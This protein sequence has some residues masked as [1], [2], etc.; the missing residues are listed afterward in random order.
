MPPAGALHAVVHKEG[1]LLG[2]WDGEPIG[3]GGVIIGDDI[4]ITCTRSDPLQPGA[5][6]PDVTVIAEVLRLAP[7]FVHIDALVSNGTTQF[8]A[9]DRSFTPTGVPVSGADAFPM[10]RSVGDGGTFSLVSPPPREHFTT[11]SRTMPRGTGVPPPI[12][13]SS[14]TVCPWYFVGVAHVCFTWGQAKSMD[15]SRPHILAPKVVE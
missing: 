1:A 3:N 13:H 9:N 11:P 14:S 7:A 10:I 12:R 15:W 2:G 5:R 4:A 8:T 6:Y